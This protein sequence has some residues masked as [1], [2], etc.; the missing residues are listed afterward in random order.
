MLGGK[1]IF[2]HGCSNRDREAAVADL[3]TGHVQGMVMS[4]RIGGIGHNLIGASV[5]L[6]MG[7]LYSQAYEDQAIGM[8]A[9]KTGLT[10]GRIC[11]EGQ[12]E[13][14][15]AIIYAN[16]NFVGDQV[17][18]E[19]KLYRGE[20]D[21]ELKR[22]LTRQEY[23][24]Y[25]NIRDLIPVTPKSGMKS[26]VTGGVVTANVAGNYTR[27]IDPTTFFKPG[28][29]ARPIDLTTL[30]DPSSAKFPASTQAGFPL[31]PENPVAATGRSDRNKAG[32]SS[33]DRSQHCQ[34]Q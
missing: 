18:I 33:Q 10:E 3:N 11:R 28:T 21:I 14:P 30:C 6:F 22:R 25:A 7:S 26:G 16:P 23:K 15:C 19:L 34:R 13:I 9:L 27:P 1:K 31:T 4:E 29:Q 12:M 20:N 24:S 17:S 32:G 8:F 5:M 2:G